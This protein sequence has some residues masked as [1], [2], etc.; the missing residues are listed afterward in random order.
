[1][2]W[3]WVALL[4]PW[5][6]LAPLFGMAFDAG[7]I[8]GWLLVIPVWSYPFAVIAAFILKR[9]DP[10]YAWLPLLNLAFPW[11]A[12]LVLDLLHIA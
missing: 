7:E 3:L 2:I 4:L 12:A 9:R 5:V 8:A 10:R 11:A 1:M 6:V